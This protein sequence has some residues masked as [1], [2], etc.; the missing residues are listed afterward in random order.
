[1][2]VRALLSAC[3]LVAACDRSTPSQRRIQFGS[4]GLTERTNLSTGDPCRFNQDVTAFS[5]RF[6]GQM[7][8]HIGLSF[9]RCETDRLGAVTRQGEQRQNRLMNFRAIVNPATAQYYAN[10]FHPAIPLEKR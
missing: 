8:D 3:L 4:P 10:L 5:H 6:T 1:M 2:A 9:I 7:V